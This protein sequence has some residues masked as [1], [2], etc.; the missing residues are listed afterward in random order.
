MVAS[1][2]SGCGWR[3]LDEAAVVEKSPQRSASTSSGASGAS[4]TSGGSGASTTSGAS[5]GGSGSSNGDSG[6]SSSNASSGG[7]GGSGGGRLSG[8]AEDSMWV[9]DYNS[10][11]GHHTITHF[12]SQEHHKQI[13]SSQLFHIYG[14]NNNHNHNKTQDTYI[15]T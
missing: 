1:N 12:Q 6:G 9:E 3:G 8:T 2:V 5:N 14:N 4:T 11:G 7:S 15:Y 13:T 10:Y